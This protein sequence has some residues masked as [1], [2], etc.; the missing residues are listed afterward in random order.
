MEHAL[1]VEGD[2]N[3]QEDAM[4]SIMSNAVVQN[5]IN[6]HWVTYPDWLKYTAAA[7]VTFLI[8]YLFGALFQRK[9]EKE[10][11]EEISSNEEVR[12]VSEELFRDLMQMI[13]LQQQQHHEQL[14]NVIEKNKSATITI[15]ADEE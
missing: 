3:L 12:Q 9:E 4:E 7:A 1:N 13:I 2:V 5:F 8:V 11:L 10:V 6:N 14:L 15:N